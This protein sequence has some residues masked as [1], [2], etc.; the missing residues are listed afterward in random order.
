MKLQRECRED[1]SEYCRMAVFRIL[2]REMALGRIGPERQSVGTMSISFVWWRVS[3]E[4]PA[5][6]LWCV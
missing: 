2:R 5:G 6:L 3:T 1:L 4:W